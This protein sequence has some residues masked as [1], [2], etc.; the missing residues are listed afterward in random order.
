MARIEADSQPLRGRH[1]V[2]QSQIHL[3]AIAFVELELGKLATDPEFGEIG[4]LPY[5]YTHHL[6]ECLIEVQSKSQNHTKMVNRL[7]APNFPFRVIKSGLFFGNAKELAYYPLPPR[8]E[9]RSTYYRWWRSAN[10]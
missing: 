9:L 4:D 10:A 1:V 6:R 7:Q 8:S 5:A 3:P 2:Q